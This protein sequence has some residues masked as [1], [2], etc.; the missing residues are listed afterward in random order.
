[1]KTSSD[2]PAPAFTRLRRLRRTE[3]LRSLVRE[4]V[5]SADR[6]ILPLFVSEVDGARVEIPSMPGV[7]RWPVEWVAQAAAE[8]SEAGVGG[9]L[10]FGIPGHKDARGSE[11]STPEGVVAP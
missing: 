10:L 8:A 4:N 7:Y 3:A 11:A 6:L 1:M 9:V 5:L 2:L